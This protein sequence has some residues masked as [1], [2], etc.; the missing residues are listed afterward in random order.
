VQGKEWFNQP[1][2]DGTRAFLKKSVP[3]SWWWRNFKDQVMAVTIES[4]Y[5]MAGNSHRWVKPDDMRRLGAALGRA[6][7]RYHGLERAPAK[8]TSR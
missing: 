3:E 2:D 4:T 1:P 6:I 5:G 7:A 8:K